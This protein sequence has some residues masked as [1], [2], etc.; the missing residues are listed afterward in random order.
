MYMGVTPLRR[1]LVYII[2][3]LLITIIASLV[4]Y[5]ILIAVGFDFNRY[6]QLYQNIL[7]NYF[8]L[9]YGRVDESAMND[10]VEFFRM[11]MFMEGLRIG[12]TFGFYVIYLVICQYFLSFQTLGR[13]ITKT[14]VVL[15]RNPD[16]RLGLGTIII[17]ELLGSFIFYTLIPFVGFVSMVF[18][19]ATGKSLVDRISGTSLVFD[20][21]IPVSDEFKSNFFTNKEEDYYN[22]NDYNENYPKDDYIDAEVKEEAPNSSDDNDDEYR[23]I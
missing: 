1:F 7:N 8:N 2:D 13:L 16:S 22:H 5:G 14:K 10:M 18:A 11:Y 17:R 21:K 9:A 4:L 15:D 3:I 12:I 6:Y 20:V 19:L 23:V